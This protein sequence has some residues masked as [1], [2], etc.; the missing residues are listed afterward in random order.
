MNPWPGNDGYLWVARL[1]QVVITTHVGSQ[2]QH[3]LCTCINVFV[4]C[5]VQIGAAAFLIGG[6]VFMDGNI[7]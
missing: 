3:A 6:S 2:V 7:F 1:C 4:P 5:P